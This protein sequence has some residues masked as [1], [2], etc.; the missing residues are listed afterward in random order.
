VKPPT[1][2]RVSVILPLYNQ[3]R[4]VGAA[5]E[6]VLDQTLTDWE[7]VIIDDGSSDG[8]ADMAARY[9][10]PRIRLLRQPNCGVSEARNRGITA[11][12]GEQVAFLD[13][14][15][16]Y[17]PAKLAAQVA[18]LDEHPD[19]GLTYVS[20]IEIDRDGNRLALVPLPAHASLAS[21]VLSFP[22]APTDLMVRRSWLDRAGGFRTGFVVNEDRDL[23][24]R[25]ALEGCVCVGVPNFLSFRR[26][27][28]RSFGD[29]TA[30]LD[31]MLR[32]L[33]TAFGDARCPPEVRSLEHAA[34]RAIYKDWAYQA[35]VQGD[36]ARA[37]MYFGHAL[38]YDPSFAW[39]D[40]R[41][42]L[43][44]LVFTAIRDGGDHEARL[45]RLEAS[46]PAALS[47]LP[48]LG[49]WMIAHGCLASGLQH[50]LW[51]R[52]EEG[53]RQLARSGALRIPIDHPFLHHAAEQLLCLEAQSGLAA[54]RQALR[55][56][57]RGLAEAGLGSCGRWLC[58]HFWLNLGFRRYQN[59][60]YGRV[61][62]TVARA[63]ARDP[64]HLFNRGVAAIAAR[65]AVRALHR[66]APST[67]LRHRVTGATDDILTEGSR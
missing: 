55:A 22:F 54:A 51:G 50:L 33:C 29:L 60:E 67:P 57:T 16:L 37:E 24:I 15:D 21:M 27:G 11:S 9:V 35:A 36:R 34:H 31:D 61:P 19:V 17:A 12:K 39:N 44:D 56:M 48:Q 38:R 59:G 8:S 1:R 10:D 30:R 52:A 45:R 49:S 53:R 2:P 63:V 65:S 32:A 42:F 20:R 25:L 41:E 7:L 47:T 58:G 43:H 14:D 28:A 62:F 18:F 23:Y 13:A 64:R 40:A 6:S 46:L 66:C 5:I 3:A 4:Y 26:L